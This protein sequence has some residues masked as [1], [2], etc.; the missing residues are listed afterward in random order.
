MTDKAKEWL[1]KKGFDPAYGARPFKHLIQ[2][3]IQDQLDMKILDG[4]FMGGDTVTVDADAKKDG[5]GF[6]A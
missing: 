2:K 4:K 1:A 5:L 3:E 6:K